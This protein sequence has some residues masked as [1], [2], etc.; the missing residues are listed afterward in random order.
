MM[1]LDPPALHH[2]EIFVVT[3]PVAEFDYR[4]LTQLQVICSCHLPQEPPPGYFAQ[5]GNLKPIFLVPR[6][7]PTTYLSALNRF[8]LFKTCLK[9]H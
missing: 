7:G 8:E 2:I 1:T 6:N 3:S 4:Q 9:T 5:S